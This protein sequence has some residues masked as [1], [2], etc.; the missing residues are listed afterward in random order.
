MLC[1]LKSNSEKSWKLS[2]KQS[3][4]NTL[5]RNIALRETLKLVL[6]RDG[7]CKN[8]LKPRIQIKGEII[9]T[10]DRPL[11][12]ETA[13]DFLDI[14]NILSSITIF[15]FCPLISFYFPGKKKYALMGHSLF[16]GAFEEGCFPGTWLIY[17]VQLLG[18]WLSRWILLLSVESRWN[19]W[20]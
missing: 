20:T 14:D 18:L 15:S 12:K 10:G 7:S 5:A 9:G 4:Q 3:S 19:Q 8:S 2:L 17:L 6:V 1:L 16:L 13:P 11:V